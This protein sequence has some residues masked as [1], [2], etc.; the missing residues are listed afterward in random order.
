MKNGPAAA[1]TLSAGAGVLVIGFLTTLSAA[2]AGIKEFLNFY[3][4]AGSLTGK[5][6]LGVIAW[7]GLW[8]LLHRAWRDQ[9]VGYGRVLLTALALAA[10]GSLFMFPPF[11]DLF[12]A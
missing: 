1:A 4:P 5:T 9:D 11:F 7:L 3:P 10:L 2:S 6:T 12:H 8:M